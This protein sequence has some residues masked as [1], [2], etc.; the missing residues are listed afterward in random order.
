[1]LASEF[2]DQPN[3]LTPKRRFRG[4]DPFEVMIMDDAI[5]ARFDAFSDST[6]E[7]LLEIVHVSKLPRN[8]SAAYVS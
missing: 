2:L 7:T 4:T 3:L 8:S 6:V 5:P 1:V